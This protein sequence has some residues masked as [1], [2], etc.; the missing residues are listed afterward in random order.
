M[1]TERDK[2]LAEIGFPLR[3]YLNLIWSL[4]GLSASSAKLLSG[5]ITDVEYQAEKAKCDRLMPVMFGLAKA[6]LEHFIDRDIIPPWKFLKVS[7]LG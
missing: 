6:R 1:K 2:F 5:E 3:N 7:Q 4:D